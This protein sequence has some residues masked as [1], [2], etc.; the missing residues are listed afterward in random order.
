[1]LS[2][3]AAEARDVDSLQNWLNGTGCVAREE[4]AYLTHTRE[5]ASLAPVR[6]SALLRIEVWVEE[7]LIRCYRGFRKV[8]DL[9]CMAYLTRL[10]KKSRIVIT[11]SQSTR[12]CICTPGA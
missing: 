10:A 5:L 8:R 1:M 4:T 9:G 11:I 7:A 2:L 6:D 3:D 12:T